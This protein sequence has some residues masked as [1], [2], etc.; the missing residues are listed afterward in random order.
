LRRKLARLGKEVQ[1]GA[2]LARVRD[3]D[4]RGLA[5]GHRRVESHVQFERGA[6]GLERLRLARPLDLGDLEVG[7]VERERRQRR[8]QRDEGHGGRARDRLLRHVEA[9]IR[10]VAL[11]VE[12]P[13]ADG[14]LGAFGEPVA[15]TDLA[16][17]TR[18][19]E[20]ARQKRQEREDAFH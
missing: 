18:C 3:R 12:R 1:T 8:P 9:Q 14:P 2:W 13:V 11:D 6:V 17:L 16:D 19:A 5:G 4:A 10:F 7:R 15:G 20:G